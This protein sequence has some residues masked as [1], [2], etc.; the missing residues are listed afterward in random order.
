[1]T[2]RHYLSYTYFLKWT[3]LNKKYY[4]S[5]VANEV[6]PRKDLLIKYDT[7]S[8]PVKRLLKLFGKPDFIQVDKTFT[9][10]QEA[11]D[12]EYN[13]LQENNSRLDPTW[14]NENDRPAPPDRT[15][16]KHTKEHKEKIGK[17][18]KNPSEKTRRIMRENNKGSKNPMFGK[19]PSK[20]TRQKIS[21][22]L[23]GG[24]SPFYGIPKT[25]EQKEKIS[26]TKKGTIPINRKKVKIDNIEFKSIKEAA[27]YFNV[28]RGT[29][30]YWI[31]IKKRGYY[32]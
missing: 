6:E 16:I 29:I 24:K 14:L 9:D 4:G 28:K 32:I 21:N 22:S 1:M 20:E 26:K 17:S 19:S 27:K 10:E 25:K 12:Y 3:I 30:R 31:N 23:K 7:S 18:N 5:R 8:D 15:G 13:F 11:R 2:A